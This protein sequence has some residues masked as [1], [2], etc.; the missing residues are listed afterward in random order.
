MER[1][2]RGVFFRSPQLSS[3][4]LRVCNISELGVGLDGSGV[5][6]EVPRGKE[7]DGKLLVG[8]S[9]VDV[10]LR[11]VHRTPTLLGFEF[12]ASHELLQGA[13]RAYFESEL[14][15]A[16]LHQRPGQG[17]RRDQDLIF[18]D[19]QG[20]SLW[21]QEGADGVLRFK[22]EVLGNVVTWTRG[23]EVEFIQNGQ[24]LALPDGLRRQLVSLVQS[25]EDVSTR[26]RVQIEHALLGSA[27]STGRTP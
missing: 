4:D 23:A 20:N 11:F 13:I 6:Q 3:K 14:V 1:R 8:R 15:G 26:D 21:I 19:E 16:S 2:L 9:S 24:K 18:E 12:A 27:P 17:P 10:R 22:I 25:I 7:L 5:T